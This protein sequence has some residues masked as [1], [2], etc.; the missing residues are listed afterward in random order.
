MFFQT[1][2]VALISLLLGLCVC[3]AGYRLF[4]ILLPIWAFFAGF[5]TTAEAIQDL[6]GGGFLATVGSWAFALVIAVLFA[7]AA[8]FFYYA[9]V[10]ILA[11]IVGYEIGGGIVSALGMTSGFLHFIVGLVLALVLSVAVVFFNLPKAFIVVLSALAGAEMILAGVLLALNR[12]S[13]EDL[14][15]GAVGAFLRSSWFWGLAF[16]AIAGAGI[17]VQLLMPHA[18]SMQPYWENQGTFEPP[19]GEA[20][21]PPAPPARTYP[22]QT[23]GPEAPAT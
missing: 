4:V 6:F 11:A 12:I 1:V 5:A 9:A 7:V 23:T 22:P 13:L 20:S 19:T 21:R 14:R 10:V 3:F 16:L 15:W 17:A 8:Y 18:Y 2:F